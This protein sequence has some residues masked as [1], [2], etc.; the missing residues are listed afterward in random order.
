MAFKPGKI[1]VRLTSTHPPIAGGFTVEVRGRVVADLTVKQIRD[2]L[3]EL[4]RLGAPPQ[5]R[6]WADR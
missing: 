1:R 3:L 5:P 2:A 4:D 6:H